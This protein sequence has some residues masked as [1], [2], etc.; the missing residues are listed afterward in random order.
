MT[1]CLFL[2]RCKFFGPIHLFHKSRH[3]YIQKPL[4]IHRFPLILII[5]YDL[6]RVAITLLLLRFVQPDRG[7]ALDFSKQTWP[8]TRLLCI[9][10]CNF[11]S[12]FD[13]L[14]QL[15]PLGSEQLAV[16]SSLSADVDEN[17]VRG[18]QHFLAPILGCEGHNVGRKRVGGERRLK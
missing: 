11:D 8:G 4:H 3:L 14:C 17:C 6:F 13:C 10:V 15:F 7:C 18:L 12:S 1:P 2:K 9:P 5:R 16:A